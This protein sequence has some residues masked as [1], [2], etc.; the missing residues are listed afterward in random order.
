MRDRGGHGRACVHEPAQLYYR[1][2]NYIRMLS[3]DNLNP[4]EAIGKSF[5]SENQ[6]GRLAASSRAV[7]QQD[8]QSIQN[9]LLPVPNATI[10]LIV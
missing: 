8:I 5:L 10:A 3:E 6:R 9:K 4:R 2:P 7:F 1:G